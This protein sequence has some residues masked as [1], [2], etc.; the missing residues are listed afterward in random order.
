MKEYFLEYIARSLLGEFGNS[1]NRH[2]LVFPGR[3]AGIYFLKYL[4]R[5]ADRPLWSPST[6]TINDLF[7][8]H[9]RLQVASNELLL[10]ELYRSYRSL[11][12]KAESF[13]EFYFWGDM[14][15]SDFDDADK[16]LADAD[17][18]FGNLRDLRNID[19]SFGALSVE[20]VDI[21]KRFWKNFEPEKPT[22][23][24]ESFLSLWAVLPELYKTFTTNLRLKNLGYEGMIYRDLAEGDLSQQVSDRRFDMYHFIGFNALN[25]CEKKLMLHLKERG[26]ARFYWDYDESFL[27]DSRQNSAGL[28]LA[29]NI[30]IFG[31]HMPESWRHNSLLND[32]GDN[33]TRV[34]IN[35]SSD[36]AQ[37]KLIPSLISSL[38]GLSPENEHHTAVVLA[39]ENLLMPL[40]SSL[41]D[42]TEAVNITMGYPLK[43]TVVYTLVRHLTDL[44]VSAR[45]IE[46]R[47]FF[48]TGAVLSILD[49]SL[50]REITGSE[51][52]E[53][54][55]EL[56]GGG[57]A[58]VEADRLGKSDFFTTLFSRA[59]T[60]R[61]LSDYLKDVLSAIAAAWTGTDNGARSPE[62]N[63]RINVTNEFIYR[64]MLSLNRLDSLMTDREITFST[65]TFIRILER[66]LSHQSV[67]F[68][69]EPLMG[70][71][72]MG[73]LETRALDFRN[74]IILSAN[75]GVLPA[76][77]GSSS[78]IPLALREAFGLPSLNHQES[79][80]AYHIYRL[81]QRAE[82]VTFVYNSNSTGLRSGEMSRFLLQMKFELPAPPAFIDSSFGIVRHA[83]PAETIERDE[84]MQQRLL[85]RFAGRG[86]ISPSAIN[87]WTGC[88]MR[89]YYRYV[90]G[91]A[92]PGRVPGE[93]DPA[94]FG[95]MLHL[96]LRE[97]YTPLAGTVAGRETFEL[98][99]RDKGRIA[100]AASA[101]CTE[102]LKRTIHHEPDGNDMIAEDVLAAFIK[103]ILAADAHAAPVYIKEIEKFIS[104]ALSFKCGEKQ[105]SLSSGGYADRIDE[106][107][108]A[109]RI[110]DYKTGTVSESVK[111]IGALF[112]PDRKKED[113]AWLQTL[114][115]CEAWLSGHPGSR[116]RP[117]VFR[118]RKSRV[119]DVDARLVLK[120]EKAEAVTVDDYTVVRDEFLEG[121]KGVIE[122]MFN[123][124]EP[125]TMTGE[126]RSRCRWCPYKGLCM[127]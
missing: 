34:V 10:F 45:T 125:F 66:L 100:A 91:L 77:S 28:F 62:E 33:V 68:S 11:N 64:V 99:R 38:P 44:Q 65:L 53:L 16:Y 57:S 24:K 92:E 25:E 50:I 74:L 81:L 15:L 94:A 116:V 122:L 8:N 102:V 48:G 31:N 127:R 86:F 51:S 101:A 22:P 98:M 96:A 14:V 19:R 104:F 2:C 26:I 49:S 41:P 35:T 54:K 84:V 70:I 63:A 115:Y 36:V 21:I 39:D 103:H 59:E 42:I 20:Q 82:N 52:V 126:R 123:I 47:T 60:P 111:S 13:D 67:P 73:I 75:E 85:S 93:I 6:I 55:E 69:G 90:C 83:S 12:S 117:S 72:V 109:V 27:K 112:A 119:E 4:S 78:F 37:V 121:L 43:H 23:E 118:V 18:L 108:S 58:L 88:R 97:L 113:D 114:V 1:L 56:A 107:G 110:V 32:N 3:R 79:I 46:G 76:I 17:M 30:R 80:F 89:F 7:R 120:K 105:V 40:L 9:S 5:H 87:T 61:A 124:N 95:S 71:Q 29:D 106:T